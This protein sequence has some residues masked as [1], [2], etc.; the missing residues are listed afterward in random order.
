VV[1]VGGSGPTDRDETVY[2]IPIFG[3]LAALLADAGYIVLRYD[4]RGVGQSGGRPEAATLTDYTEDLRAV[5]KTLSE[6]KDVDNKKIAV[7]GH[8]EGGAISM[9]AAAKDNR[10]AALALV[11]S[12]GITGAELNLAQVNH[13]LERSTRSD[14]EK[15]STVN[16][17]KQ[18]Q[19]AVLTGKG[20]ETIPPGL[21]KQAD[22]PW[23]QSFLAFDPAKPMAGTRQP[24]LIVQG[25]LDTQVAPSNADRLEQLAQGRKKGAKV[26]VAKIPGVNH[27][28]VPATTGEVDEYASL[29]EE[30]VSPAV[31]EAIV[32][33][34]GK[35][36]TASR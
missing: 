5:L 1:L 3:Q 20:W 29:S 30:T 23:F 11:A 10:I 4:K 21:R 16:L 33:W 13:A 9:L 7:V 32:G 6:R 34:L 12:L 2:G 28:L 25:L 36:F 18:I 31:A 27:L 26:E 24:I 15:Q 22:V 8:S 19:A 14:A 35:T 17:Q